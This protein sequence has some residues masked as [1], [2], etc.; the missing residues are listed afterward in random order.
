[1][2][3]YTQPLL[4]ALLTLAFGGCSKDHFDPKV[5]REQGSLAR[6]RT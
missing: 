2:K 4:F 6:D 3:K 5:G 1:M